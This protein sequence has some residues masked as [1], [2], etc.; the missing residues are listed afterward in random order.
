MLF[1]RRLE[2]R[3]GD[4]FVLLLVMW[5]WFCRT[6]CWTIR[7]SRT[8]SRSP[9]T[10]VCSPL[11]SQV[12]LLCSFASLYITSVMFLC[13]LMMKKKLFFFVCVLG[14]R[15]SYSRYQFWDRCCGNRPPTV[16]LPVNFAMM[17]ELY[18]G[19]GSPGCFGLYMRHWMVYQYV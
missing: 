7:A 4:W 10:S 17:L 14:L 2:T 13:V 1:I 15:L 9:S 18:I 6:S 12:C 16:I 8:C 5:F 11:A 3:R 19:H